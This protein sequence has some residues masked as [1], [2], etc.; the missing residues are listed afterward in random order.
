MTT[1]LIVLLVT[2]F[3]GPGWLFLMAASFIFGMVFEHWTS[4]TLRKG[5]RFSSEVSGQ[6]KSTTMTQKLPARYL[7]M[8]GYI[9]ET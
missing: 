6:P 7:R 9:P 3:T 5:E 1:A 2:I 4:K 8:G